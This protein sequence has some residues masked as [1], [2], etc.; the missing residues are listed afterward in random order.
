MEFGKLLEELKELGLADGE[1]A[2]FGSGPLAVRRIR[3]A[4]DLDII[5]TNN[6]YKK[7]EE[8]YPKEGCG[9]KIGDIE[10]ISPDSSVVVNSKKII[11]RAELINGFR[12]TLLEDIINWKEKMSRPKD[13]K[14][15][16]L[17][18]N[19]LKSKKL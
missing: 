1:Y 10:I 4:K 13:I 7:L 2:V 6:L 14:D 17:I 15:I 11:K 9:L 16:E 3:E 5:V 18:N 12:F 19:Y 8:K